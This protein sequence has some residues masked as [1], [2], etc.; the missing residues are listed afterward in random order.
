MLG[1][2]ATSRPPLTRLKGPSTTLIDTV[3]AFR[4]GHRCLF[5]PV[6]VLIINRCVVFVWHLARLSNVLFA[7]SV[8]TLST[9]SR[10]SHPTRSLTSNFSRPA[11]QLA[12]QNLLDTSE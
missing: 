8:T 1:I 2:T 5:R 9:S 3:K 6:H 12:I 7:R 11:H 10:K 4:D